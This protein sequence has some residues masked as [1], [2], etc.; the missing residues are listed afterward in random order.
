MRGATSR[1]AGVV[2]AVALWELLPRLGILPAEYIPPASVVL[3]TLVGLFGDGAFWSDVGATLSGWAIGLVLST[4]VAVPLGLLIGTNTALHRAT[5]VIVEFFRPIPSVALIPLAILV[6]G[7][8]L[9]MKVFLIVFATFWPILVQS[10]YGVQ[11]VDPVARDSA[12]SFGLNRREIFFH[13]TLPSA[14]PYVVT[15]LRLASALA[16]V[17][18]VTAELVAGAP[19]LGRSILVAQSAGASDLMY[20]L[21]VVT[22]L[23]SLL[24]SAALSAAERRLLH[25]HTSHRAVQA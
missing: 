10:V 21:I 22:G 1:W 14:A 9:D 20:A 15:G 2:A 17:L 7:I 6:F 16:I 5:R 12:R 3:P 24:L 8:T 23:V 4:V 18:A 13:I 25:W 19:G 11:D